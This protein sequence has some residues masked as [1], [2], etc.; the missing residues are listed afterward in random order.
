[1]SEDREPYEDR[2]DNFFGEERSTLNATSFQ[3]SE[4]GD[5]ETLESC[6]SPRTQQYNVQDTPVQYSPYDISPLSSLPPFPLTL[7]PFPCLGGRGEDR[8]EEGEE[9][10]IRRQEE[11]EEEKEEER[12]KQDPDGEEGEEKLAKEDAEW[13]P[14]KSIGSQFL[15]ILDDSQKK[16]DKL[17]DREGSG[18]LSAHVSPVAM[19]FHQ[20]STAIFAEGHEHDSLFHRE[21]S[22][23]DTAGHIRR[24][25][26]REETLENNSSEEER[27]DDVPTTQT[28]K[29]RTKIEAQ[30][31][32]EALKQLNNAFET[33]HH[34]VFS[35]GSPLV[36]Q[37]VLSASVGHMLKKGYGFNSGKFQCGH[38]ELVKNVHEVLDSHYQ[39]SRT[40]F[41]GLYKVLCSKTNSNWMRWIRSSFDHMPLF[42]IL[43]QKNSQSRCFTIKALSLREL[44]RSKLD[45][46]SKSV[47]KLVEAWAA[48]QTCYHSS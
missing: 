17:L 11:G 29:R 47:I 10:K 21:E 48:A 27:I 9:E 40:E 45:E 20:Y 23:V 4:R 14:S 7:S 30:D 18:V 37:F 44:D 26:Q 41:E 24:K 19:G 25:R 35:G 2:S 31:S 3:F 13:H 8:E 12:R 16:G 28:K 38:E 22:A 42:K 46:E 39:A 32:L 34:K 15:V 36:V 33:D 6:F 43:S 1:M 5:C